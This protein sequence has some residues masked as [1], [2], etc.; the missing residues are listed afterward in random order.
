MILAIISCIL[1]SAAHGDIDSMVTSGLADTSWTPDPQCPYPGPGYIVYFPVEGDCT[2]FIECWGGT[3]YEGQC[4]DGLWWHQD[5]KICDY[6]GDYCSWSTASNTSAPTV[7]TT[8]PT[9]TTPAVGPD[10]RCTDGNTSYWPHP[11]SCNKYIE[12]YQGNSYEMVCPAGLY[13]SEGQ[14][15]CVSSGESEC[16]LANAGCSRN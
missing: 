11:A 12:C 4:T 13:F 7:P 6:P 1:F 15:K 3:K 16:C 10:P 2:K 9:P 8:N 14:K 5:L